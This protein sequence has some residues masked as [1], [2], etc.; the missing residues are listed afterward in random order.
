MA[1][2][3]KELDDLL[4]KNALA[5]RHPEL[6]APVPVGPP[7]DISDLASPA[8]PPKGDMPASHE[9]ISD[10][11]VPVT[12]AP[13]PRGRR[14]IGGIPGPVDPATAGWM[15][16]Q[17]AAGQ[18]PSTVPR[19][20]PTAPRIGGKGGSVARPATPTA[21]GGV[22]RDFGMLTP[23]EAR[24]EVEARKKQAESH[25]KKAREKVEQSR[26]LQGIDLGFSP[27]LTPVIE[28]QRRE[29]QAK[30]S[31]VSDT[32]EAAVTRADQEVQRRQNQLEGKEP[33]PS[34]SKL[35]DFIDRTGNAALSTMS[36]SLIQG[37]GI[38]AG[39]IPGVG[40]DN[41]L[42]GV[43]DALQEEINKAFPGDP[44]RA[45]EFISQLGQGTGSMIGFMIGSV[46][47][48]AAG[49]AVGMSERG[50]RLLGPAGLGG[51]Q[52]GQ[53]GYEEAKKAGADKLG[54][55]I[56]FFANV[57][58]GTTEAAPIDRFFARLDRAT[59]GGVQH[60]LAETT[61]QTLT[62]FTQEAVQQFG[63]NFVAK[64]IYDPERP[65]DAGV[66]QQGSI[67]GI[68]GA[69]MGFGGGVAHGHEGNAL[70]APGA[71][72]VRVPPVTATPS[73][74]SPE[75][76]QGV[77][78][79]I[80]VELGL[81]PGEATG[82]APRPGAA[83]AEATQPVN[84]S[85]ATPELQ[86]E[87]QPGRPTPSAT[88]EAGQI[89]VAIQAITDAQAKAGPDQSAGA[90]VALN[91]TINALNGLKG[92]MKGARGPDASAS[93]EA[94]LDAAERQIS[95]A[96]MTPGLEPQRD[97][98]AM[99]AINTAR[100]AIAAIRGVMR[101]G[102]IPL[103]FGAAEGTIAARQPVEG[104]AQAMPQAPMPEAFAPPIGIRQP[105]T[106]TE[107]QAGPLPG[108]PEAV[109]PPLAVRQPITGEAVPGKPPAAPQAEGQ[110][111]VTQPI[112][113]GEAIAA[114]PQG[115]PAA[116]GQIGVTQPIAPGE[117]V[118][119]PPP[120]QPESVGQIGVQQPIA[121]TAQTQEAPQ[122]TAEA[123]APIQITQPVT[124][125][126]VA[127]A[128]PEP[129]RAT[130]IAPEVQAPIAPGEAAAPAT[131]PATSAGAGP[132]AI[133]QP[134]TGTEAVPAPPPPPATAAGTA[135]GV[136][137]ISDIASPVKGEG[138]LKSPAHAVTGPEVARAGKQAVEPTEAQAKAG[139]YQKGHI[140]WNG[141][142]IAIETPEGGVR[143]GKAPDG[144]AWE[145]TM[146]AAYG[147][148]KRTKSTDG[149]QVDITM[150]PNPASKHVF[151]IDQID[152]ET[153]KPDE[154]K[155]FGGFDTEQ[156]VRDVYDRSFSDNSGR[157]RIGSL[158]ETNVVDFRKWL[159]S[160]KRF[161][162]P[163][164]MAEVTRARRD[165]RRNAPKKPE[166]VVW[167]YPILS[168]LKQR[169]GVDP[170]SE[171]AGEL[172][173]MGVTN[174][175]LPGLFAEGGV[176]AVDN[177]PLAENPMFG[178]EAD[179]GHGYVSRDS[180]LAAV[181]DELHGSPRMT[182]EQ[183]Q[184]VDAYNTQI[185][186]VALDAALREYGMADDQAVKERTRALMAEGEDVD[187]AI[188]HAT[189]QVAQESENVGKAD[190][191]GRSAE[192]GSGAP[193]FGEG[194]EGPA[195]Q[196]RIA[197]ERGALQEARRGQSEEGAQFAGR[198]E[199]AGAEGRPQLVLPGAE[200]ITQ[201]EEA[202]RA[203][204]RALKP[205]V[206][207]QPAGGL[208]GE[209]S[210][211]ID[212][213][214]LA[215]QPPRGGEHAGTVRGD[216]GQ[217]PQRSEAPREPN[218][219]LEAPGQPGG[220]AQR[221]SRPSQ[222]ATA[223][224]AVKPIEDFGE[225]IAGARKM[226]AQEYSRKLAEDV[227]IEAAPLSESFPQPNYVK[228][229]EEGV[230]GRT[231]ALIAL[232]RDTIPRKPRGWK[233]RR[234]VAQV[235][236][237]RG[238][239]GK[240]LSGEQSV[241]EVVERMEK[242]MLRDLV[243]TAEAIKHV[244]PEKLPQAAQWRI[245]SGNYSMF[246]GER[247]DPPKTL[248]FVEPPRDLRGK[249]N[250]A[251]GNDPAIA[252][253]ETREGAIKNGR[254]IVDRV[255]AAE[256][257]APTAERSKYTKVGIYRDTRTREIYIGFKGRST[258]LRVKA[259]FE[260]VKDARAYLENSRDEI[261]ATIDEM[262]KGPRERLEE[263]Q[264]RT[265]LAFRG[266][267]NVTP[268][269][270][271][272]AFGFRG[273]QF[274]N[275]V[276]GERRQA[277]L[278]RAYD[279]LMDLAD[280]LGVPP[281]ALSLNG[282]LGLA[283][284]ARGHGGRSAAAAHFEPD[285]VAINL[286]KGGG[287]GSLA[288]EWL[289]GLDNYFARQDVGKPSTAHISERRRETGLVRDPVYKAWKAIE[290]ELASGTYA[291]RSVK[292]DE[293]R[294]KPYY[295]LTIEKAAR[296]FERFIVDRLNEKGIRNDYLANIDLSG[297]AYPTD[298]EMTGG[299]TRAYD[300]LFAAIKTRETE[301]GKIEMYASPRRGPRPLDR[302]DVERAVYGIIKRVAA[303]GIEHEIVDR[304]ASQNKAALARSGY[305]GT[306]A[307]IPGVFLPLEKLVVIAMT[308]NEQ[309]G[310][311]YH[312]AWHSLEPLVFNKEWELFRRE[313]Q[314]LH[315]SA[316]KY[317]GYSK[318]SDIDLSFGEIV[319]NAF[320]A[321]AIGQHAGIHAGIRRAFE[322]VLETLRRIRNH[323]RKL[324]YRTAEDI[325][326]EAF[327]GRMR[328]R[329]GEFSPYKHRG[330][331]YEHGLMLHPAWHGSRA[332]FDKFS[333]EFIGSGEGAQSYGW[334]HYFSSL[335]EIAEHYRNKLS[336][337]LLINGE[338]VQDGFSEIR[339]YIAT[340]TRAEAGL[341]P[342]RKLPEGWRVGTD[343]MMPPGRRYHI[344]LAGQVHGRPF[345]NQ[346]Y[347]SASEAVAGAL[348][349][350][351]AGVDGNVADH[352]A[353]IVQKA[354]NEFGGTSSEQLKQAADAYVA[355][356]DKYQREL[357]ADT[358][359]KRSEYGGSLEAD[360]AEAAR[361]M[362]QVEEGAQ[363]AEKLD[364]KRAQGALYK[365]EIPEEDSMLLW[366][367]PLSEQPEKV[368]EGLRKLGVTAD[369]TTSLDD[370]PFSDAMMA[371]GERLYR[372]VADRLTLADKDKA[373]D[374]LFG[375]HKAFQKAYRSGPERASKALHDA[376]ISGIKYLAG[377]SRAQ[378]EGDYNYVV[379]DDA[380]IE[381]IEHLASR[382]RRS[383]A[384]PDT[385]EARAVR[386]RIGEEPRKGMP[387]WHDFYAAMKDDLDPVQRATK[388]LQ[389]MGASIAAEKNPYILAR[390]ARGTHGMAEHWIEKKT[391]AFADRHITGKGLREIIEPVKTHLDG[392]R[393]FLLA[394]R[395]L[396][397][398]ERGIE[399]GIPYGE[400]LVTVRDGQAFYGPIQQE[401][402]DYQ[403]RL[404][405]YLV[406]AGILQ[407]D[408]AMAMREANLDYVPFYRVMDTEKTG[409][410]IGKPFH[411]KNPIKGIRG[412]G[413]KIVDPI[414]SIVRNTFTFIDLAERNRVLNAYVSLAE[415]TGDPG[416]DLARKIKKP[417]HPITVSE[418]EVRRFMR[419]N[420]I[421]G[422][423][424]P[425]TIF[426]PNT[427]LPNAETIA[428]FQ[429][430]KQV[431]YE[432]PPEVGSALQSLNREQ[433]HF[434]FRLLSGPAKL[435]RAGATLAPEFALRNPIRDQFTAFVVSD[436]GY[437]PFISFL[438]GFGH[439]L[440][441]D[442]VYWEWMRNGGANANLVSLDRNY[443]RSE[444][445]R[446][447]NPTVS[448]RALLIAKTPIRALRIFSELTENATRVGDFA[449]G[450]KQGQGGTQSA[451]GS[452]EVTLDFAR[453]GSKGAAINKIVAFWNAQVEGVDRVARAL[454][455]HP[456]RTLFRLAVSITL[457]SVLLWY[458]NHDDPRW[459]ELPS[460]QRDL[461]W[462]IFT[463]KWVA[464]AD[465]KELK[466][467]RSA[468]L[469]REV[470]GRWEINKGKTWR[471]P[472]P[473]ELGVLFGS[474]PERILDAYFDH[475]PHAFDNIGWTALFALTPAYLPTVLVPTIEQF[476][477]WSTFL[478]RPIIPRSQQDV[479]PEYQ[480][481][482]YTSESAKIIAKAI[483]K[484]PGAGDTTLASPYIIENYVRG[485]SGG[486][487]KYA[488]DIS[489]QMLKRLG[490]VPEP[491]PEPTPVAADLPLLRGFAV[492]YPD[493]STQSITQFY[494]YWE[495]E[496]HREQTYRFLLKEGRVKEAQEH[497]RGLATGIFGSSGP[498]GGYAKAISAQRKQI[499]SIYQNPDI[500]PDEKRRLIDMIYLQMTAIAKQGVERYEAI[501][502]G[503]SVKK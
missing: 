66:L 171:L 8:P 157:S 150:G 160:D 156:Q 297:G 280:A 95:A 332:R 219:E 295:N 319:A 479:E 110:I 81:T 266:D 140:R 217:V 68:L 44:V 426:R 495:R 88:A 225:V 134:I 369:P 476:A 329:G 264:P 390:L 481:A 349:S 244:A 121:G 235:E 183:Q 403:D 165:I 234:W 45:E 203:A 346:R 356:Q 113:P 62:E 192:D 498:L 385:R 333:S 200:R 262:R 162:N 100:A 194:G 427:L 263:N 327:A 207:Q 373:L 208:F 69:I 291:E 222:E 253:S 341:P 145:V 400:A 252:H 437:K 209:S 471:I 213:M 255:L 29:E 74:A 359:A 175:T 133:S 190:T 376:G 93:A 180:V 278:N 23:E 185:D 472:K 60:L 443:I 196:G 365:V 237:I 147:Y 80:E 303:K 393:S 499:H 92:Q 135:P 153:G 386:D 52:Q 470:N 28:Q 245:K 293:A 148:I 277:D 414:E 243:D 20:P 396:E 232:M 301:G 12:H 141:L 337:G 331:Q 362:A 335:R 30:P 256:S 254:T 399:T 251:L 204:D 249:F 322:R 446:I 455:Q 475:D 328:E 424:A 3:L 167:K 261:Q 6:I 9:D 58:L 421:E 105:I 428:P 49:R 61:A 179:D 79:A 342:L 240:L 40:E 296:S 248:Y 378:G 344:L 367:K 462:I 259:G 34:Q 125:E 85:R 265:G 73:G 464:P 103:Q 490:V 487:G 4:A 83:A 101:T 87:V 174:K 381:I 114:S 286:T 37:A 27:E 497:G 198:R 47:T 298:A 388:Y 451:F 309:E 176:G 184:A 325:F 419:D 281:K 496:L 186:E 351:S 458:W 397:L 408:A 423:A 10:L 155:A 143:R 89:G 39:V 292:F 308:G 405:H 279:A 187:S 65:L 24:K 22:L 55:Y 501:R 394:K 228:L 246:H 284:G 384:P 387:T 317:L 21:G 168:T 197:P 305:T 214:D 97:V 31:D 38:T 260:N 285:M 7:D 272:E 485:W 112:P 201:R 111:G 182:S 417:V 2:L 119:G 411:V 70:A 205:K 330:A 364:V 338:Q 480:G 345:E 343:R 340:R 484:I 149:Q 177:W 468:G 122:A 465:D 195:A 35:R 129:A 90:E 216:Q 19:Q 247:F 127:G 109:A 96:I 86:G 118:A 164:A 320:E 50:A 312:E 306:E 82:A 115:Q 67:G 146:P 211:Q 491:P 318:A 334:G 236:A 138:T 276:E 461:F 353:M 406:D 189:F 161:F 439:V 159:R 56:S 14:P 99:Q 474:V 420:S 336:K 375:S 430:G 300:D 250:T 326:G 221:P 311:A 11:A 294:S 410:R 482:D 206:E 492:R 478:D 25:A 456:L 220:R 269:R 199:E 380:A 493:A 444:L 415:E 78:R 447:A 53:Q 407:L 371:K 389:R 158:S 32:P 257:E 152:P 467:Y 181:R 188:E 370:N 120:T 131:P 416:L 441:R 64:Y 273:V 116:V 16:G 17:F 358:E 48:G 401:I 442:K 429:D 5:R 360:T 42:K 193:P 132:L 315:E 431:L 436:T 352:A 488:L 355:N 477:N 422:D 75:V 366:D 289:H 382:R 271:S 46:V 139:N 227:D 71:R 288:H 224:K 287:P 374:K 107:A 282:T 13:Q 469:A 137:D 270:F 172:R 230:Q 383:A 142:T 440:G 307:D 348:K 313:K 379:F 77:A 432:V 163:K 170:R 425:F 128:P 483:S 126:M 274:G 231:L 215:A 59:N 310:V 413:R 43:G 241:D 402:V 124:G 1:D 418:A 302:I 314:R 494:E 63:Q 339:D 191:T 130:G 202:Q 316:A 267:E 395:A 238:F 275:Y 454:A 33:L 502:Q 434:I 473:F 210:K 57:G 233:L 489:D 321:Y 449:R 104:Q 363:V 445:L 123:R 144:T 106:G 136:A 361:F 154:P 459:K 18:E 242:T 304:I 435:L 486:L 173:H 239:V 54:R 450:M 350:L 166:D 354:Q 398:Y 453:L 457:P 438:R 290:R 463:D 347:A 26:Q 108:Q 151:M 72:R 178:P 76:A 299:I 357:I 404:L 229:A 503:K 409:M 433:M 372:A 460:W 392:L 500:P 391:F 41:W 15:A 324:G 51:M 412:S 452:R 91:L 448:Q 466:A 169:G 368:K 94:A 323:F 226:L 223:A 117:A 268:D 102:K 98:Q 36:S 218:L 212:L 84:V 258:V 377:T 283:F